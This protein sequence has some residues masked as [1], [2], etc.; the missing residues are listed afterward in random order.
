MGPV[1][2]DAVARAM[3]VLERSATMGVIVAAPTAGSAGVVPGCVLALA[4]HL[5]LDEEQVMNALYCA[6][7]IGPQPHHERLRRRRRGRMSGRGWKRCRHGR[8]PRWSR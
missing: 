4:D 6:A 8:P 5:Q 7:A 1:Q 3:A 2:T